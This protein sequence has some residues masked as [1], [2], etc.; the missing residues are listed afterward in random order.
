MILYL[1]VECGTDLFNVLALSGVQVALVFGIDF[2]DL[3]HVPVVPSTV[4]VDVVVHGVPMLNAAGVLAALFVLN[5]ASAEVVG[6]TD[7]NLC[8]GWICAT[9]LVGLGLGS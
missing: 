1:S 5:I 6:G 3:H 7:I 2:C 8:D 4:F 9:Q